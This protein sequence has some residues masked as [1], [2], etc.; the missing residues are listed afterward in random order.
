MA[1]TFPNQ[2]RIAV[3]AQSVQVPY[4]QGDS[5]V[6]HNIV[7]TTLYRVFGGVDWLSGA[8]SENAQHDRY[9]TIANGTTDNIRVKKVVAATAIAGSVSDTVFNYT[10][11]SGASKEIFVPK[12]YELTL[13]AD[14]TGDVTAD[15]V[16]LK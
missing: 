14:A 9:I 10:I 5:D 4:T 1:I 7:A 12:G 15:E 13:V 11:A 16:C 3:P 2:V 8:A 6:V